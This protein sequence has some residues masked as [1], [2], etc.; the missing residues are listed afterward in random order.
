MAALQPDNELALS[1]TSP[2][3]PAEVDDDACSISSDAGSDSGSSLSSDD[4]SPSFHLFVQLPPEIR[5]LIWAHALP[6]P[7]SGINFFNVH[8]FPMDHA[9]CNRSTSP[10]WLYLD[11]RRL[12]IVDTDD[13]VAQYDP[14]VWQA[15]SALRAACTEARSI[16]AIPP[17]KLA[18][19]VLTRPKRGLYCR[20]G[21]DKLRRFTPYTERQSQ[22]RPA[23]PKVTRTIHL[24]AD[25]IIN[26]SIENCSFNLPWE[27]TL[28]EERST[29][30][31]GP[32]YDPGGWGFDPQ[33]TPLPVGTHAHRYCVSMIRGQGT[34]FQ[35]LTEALNEAHHVAHGGA[36]EDHEIGFGMLEAQTFK[37][38]REAAYRTVAASDARARSEQARLY[39]DRF[40]DC[41]VPQAWTTPGA[42]RPWCYRLTKVLPESNDLRDQYVRSALLQSPKRP[43]PG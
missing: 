6:P 38:G 13:E 7:G 32:G 2:S 8:A 14:S 18:T 4:F 20:A 40:G 25:D 43:A 10:P 16:C 5:H 33:L 22:G 15:R 39:W 21:D 3:C 26:L 27:D 35:T 11:L 17:D 9:G 42:G 12:S 30:G 28:D 1:T 36:P 31:I 23:E 37:L 41:Y 19:V 34:H 29:T 24:N